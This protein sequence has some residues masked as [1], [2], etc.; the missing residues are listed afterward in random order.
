[1]CPSFD[2]A[3]ASTELPALVALHARPAGALVREA[4]RFTAR[5]E[6][7]CD[8][9]SADASSILELLALGASEGSRL[10]IA[11]SGEDAAEAVAHLA[12]FIAGLSS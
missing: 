1:M 8:G 10:T 5:I 11:A 6:I 4:S 2:A 9:R 12:E 7:G 3:R